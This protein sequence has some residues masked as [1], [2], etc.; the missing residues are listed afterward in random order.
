M[1]NISRRGTSWQVQIRRKGHPIYRKTFKRKTNAE[2]WAQQI[3]ADIEAGRAIPL[4]TARRYTLKELIAAYRERGPLRGYSKREQA[5]REGKLAWWSKQLGRLY[6]ADLTSPQI[7]EAKSRLANQEGPGGKPVSPATQV[8][9]LATLS[10][11][12]AYAVKELGW[13]SV[14]PVKNVPRP[15]EPRGRLRFLS[16]D[17]RDRLLDACEASSD[18]RLYA[19]V[20]LALGTGARQGEL[21]RLRW[22]DVDFI[23]SRAVIEKSKNDERRTLSLSAKPLAALR[24][25]FR[26]RQIASDLVFVGRRGVAAFPQEAWD[27]AV[28]AAKLEE[29]FRFHDLR[30]TFASYLAMSGATLAELSEALGHKTLAMVKRYAHLSQSHTSGV[31]RRMAEKF[32]S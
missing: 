20:I 2:K 6:L 26:V 32:L 1:A 18:R 13:I 16:E 29:R 24:D 17:E 23:N 7:A 4:P 5:Q 11:V 8:R 15:R 14:N 21:L 10:H 27:A 22:R 31:V 9:Y 25:L 30:H 12:L 19:L 28:A 3:E